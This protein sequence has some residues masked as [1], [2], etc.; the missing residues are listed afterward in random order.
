MGIDAVVPKAVD[1]SA[2]ILEAEY[3][4][5]ALDTVIVLAAYDVW[6]KPE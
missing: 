6:V 1:R 5:G 2:A 3:P 4:D